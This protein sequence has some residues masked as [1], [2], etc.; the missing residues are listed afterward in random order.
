MYIYQKIKNVKTQL[1]HK[2]SLKKKINV[3]IIIYHS[4]Q[5]ISINN[6]FTYTL[7]MLRFPVKRNEEH[8]ADWSIGG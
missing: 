4:S 3:Y 6:L 7:K 1:K 5:N 2:F 8:R